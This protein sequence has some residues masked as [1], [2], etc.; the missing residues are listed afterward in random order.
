MMSAVGRH[1][2]VLTDRDIA[3]V[4]D[5]ANS[6]HFNELERSVL[7]LAAEMT[8]T[9]V[10]IDEDN[11]ARLKENFSSKQIVELCAS[12]SWENQRARLDHALGIESGGFYKEPSAAVTA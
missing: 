10:R 12:I 9:P 2:A 7:Q 5:Y 3:E 1:E 11:F 6:D 4:N 8:D